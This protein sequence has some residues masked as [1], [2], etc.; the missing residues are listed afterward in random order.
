[1]KKN[2]NQNQNQN[3]KIKKNINAIFS[4]FNNIIFFNSI[5]KLYIKKNSIL[6]NACKIIFK[7]RYYEFN[8]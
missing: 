2:Q 1:M 6:K 7:S 8:S 3:Q 5:L 4:L